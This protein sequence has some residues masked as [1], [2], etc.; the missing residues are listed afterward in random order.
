MVHVYPNV[1]ISMENGSNHH[2][3]PTT[4]PISFPFVAMKTFF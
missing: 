4:Q 3:T 1:V 2:K